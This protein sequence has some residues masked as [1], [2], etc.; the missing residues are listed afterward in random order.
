MSKE[1]LTD[2]QLQ[3]ITACLE[4][5]KKIEA[6]KAYRETTGVGLAE[7][8]EFIDSYLSSLQQEFPERFPQAKGCLVFLI[9]ALLPVVYFL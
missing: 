8:K 4:E 6:I 9:G 7:A 3:E 5:G 2:E 1:K